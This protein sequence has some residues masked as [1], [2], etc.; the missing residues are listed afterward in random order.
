MNAKIAIVVV[1]GCVQSVYQRKG[2]GERAEVDVF[3]CDG[4]SKRE[5]QAKAEKFASDGKWVPVW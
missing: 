4:D 2:T 1:G 5:S 3:D